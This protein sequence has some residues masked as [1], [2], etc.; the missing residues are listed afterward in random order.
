ML[1][2]FCLCHLFWGFPWITK[3]IRFFRLRWGD[4]WMSFRIIS[5]VF[6]ILPIRNSF[7]STA[8]I[9][10]RWRH[11]LL[12]N[13]A[14]CLIIICLQ[15]LHRCGV[16]CHCALLWLWGLSSLSVWPSSPFFS[17]QNLWLLIT[18]LHVLLK[19]LKH[20]LFSLGWWLL[21][22]RLCETPLVLLSQ[23]VGEI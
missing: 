12:Q 13:D 19:L 2:G 21:S 22:Q 20:R 7:R 4:Q 11:R 17:F 5:I 8:L 14:L 18:K 9:K 10:V 23:R 1:P 6:Q 16:G 15:V 3:F